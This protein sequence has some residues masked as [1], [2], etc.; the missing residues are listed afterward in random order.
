MR[1]Q[2]ASVTLPAEPGPFPGGGSRACPPPGTA[3]G[4]LPG[5]GVGD[6]G[7]GPCRVPPQGRASP[8][9]QP[10]RPAR[11]ARCGNTRGLCPLQPCFSLMHVFLRHPF[12]CATNPCRPAAATSF[13]TNL[14][15]TPR[16]V[17]SL[18]FLPDLG[19]AG[20]A[21]LACCPWDRRTVFP[22]DQ[23]AQTICLLAPLSVE[24]H[25]QEAARRLPKMAALLPHCWGVYVHR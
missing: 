7:G 6:R 5:A 3:G 10:R 1:N 21:G 19:A 22:S 14:N 2:P 15:V 8:S 4:P 23:H 17:T 24:E 20:G 13:K 9:L 12:D 18:L 25:G 11:R 16:P